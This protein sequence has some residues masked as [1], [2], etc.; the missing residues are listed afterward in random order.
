MKKATVS[1]RRGKGNIN[2]NNRVFVTDNVDKNKTKN[3]I[4]YIKKDLKQLYKEI[5][6]SSV[7]EYN[8]KQTRADRKIKNYYEK[9]E[10]SKQEKLFYEII[11]Q[12]GDREFEDKDI[13]KK[14][15]DKYMKDFE[16]RNPNLK[17]CNAVM[18]LDEDSPHLHIDFVPVA[19]GYKRGMTKRNSISK[20]LN[21][22]LVNW[23]EREREYI[24]D[25]SKSYGVEIVQKNEEKRKY[26]SVAKYKALQDEI[27]ELNNTKKEL[28][29]IIE[30]SVNEFKK[31]HFCFKF[32][33]GD[34]QNMLVK[35]LSSNCKNHK[36]GTLY[37]LDTFE[38]MTNRLSNIYDRRSTTV[39]VIDPKNEFE[40]I[41]P[42][43]FGKDV[44][45]FNFKDIINKSMK[46]MM[47]NS[48]NIM[49]DFSESIIT[50]VTK[51]QEFNSKGPEL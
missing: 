44:G 20:A 35:I 42:F 18:H 36:E 34:T 3:N 6:Q 5:F 12:V 45:H 30:S 13:S 29:K 23:Y 16:Q 11:V 7:D 2:H 39:Y 48:L 25:I 9:I 32:K 51:K 50:N 47:V 28:D 33:A 31:L 46:N 17:V 24:K 1:F 15:L 38:D 40:M 8:A 14:I 21:G 27:K 49:N 19:K 10:R 41:V 26:L 43:S 4:V 37:Q 22:Q